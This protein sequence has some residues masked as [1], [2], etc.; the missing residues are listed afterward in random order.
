MHG[1]TIKTYL[2]YLPLLNSVAKT[3]WQAR[4]NNEGVFTHPCT[5]HI[6]A[7]A[8]WFRTWVYAPCGFHFP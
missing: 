4:K 3:L 8:S 7:Y 1:A 6:Y 5:P 2:F